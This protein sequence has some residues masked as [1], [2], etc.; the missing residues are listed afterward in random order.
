MKNKFYHNEDEQLSA[1][2]DALTYEYKSAIVAGLIL[3]IDVPDLALE[4]HISL[5]DRPLSDFLTSLDRVINLI[6]KSIAGL[7]NERIRLHK[8]YR[9][10]ES[11]HDQ[12]VLLEK[13]LPQLFEV[14]VDGSL[15]PFANPRHQHEL[16]LFKT[17]KV[18]PEQYLIFGAID[19]LSTFLEHPEVIADRLELAARFIGEFRRIMAGTDC[20][21]DTS[22]GM[23][24]LK[25]DIVWVNLRSFAEGS[26][27]ASS[28]LL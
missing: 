5:H 6:D 11:P 19:T 27:L 1:V 18:K 14:N 17:F 8:C 4:R 3:R 20:G 21:F 28:R 23:D 16:R 22:A 7:L 26:K 12:D 15:F 9:N 25:S 2:A 13:T 10:Y 24:R